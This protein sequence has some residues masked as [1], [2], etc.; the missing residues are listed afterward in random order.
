MRWPATLCAMCIATAAAVGFAQEKAV[1]PPVTPSQDP[2]PEGKVELISALRGQHPRLAF[3]PA[4]VERLRR[5]AQGAGNPFYKQLMEYLPGCIPPTSAKFQTDADDAQRQAF[6]RLPT[7]ALHYVL[8]GEKQSLDR[9]TGYLKFFVDQ[10]NWET[11]HNRDCEMSA[12]NIMTGAALAY[13][14]LYHDLDPAF[15]EKLRAKLFT[16][17]RRMYYGGHLKM[18]GSV[19]FWQ[20]DPQNNHRWINDAGLALCVLAVADETPGSGWLLEKT[21]QELEFIARW[22]PKDGSSHESS[23]Y[24]V[25]GMPYLVLAFDAADRCLGTDLLSHDYFKNNVAFRRHTLT[26]GFKDALHYA[27]SGGTGWINSYSFK[28]ASRNKLADEQAFLMDF[29]AASPK[30]FTYGWP[31]LIWFDDSLSGG[32]LKKLDRQRFFPDI[33]IASMRDGW[34]DQNVAA[35]FKCSPYGGAAL[36]EFRN[37]NNFQYVNVAHDD[38]DANIFQLY[39]RGETVAEDDR[40][41]SGAKLTAAHNTILVDGKGQK[42]EG[43]HWMQPLRGADQDMTRMAWITA[44]KQSGPVTAVEGEASGS[45][46]SLERYRRTAIWVEGAY[47]LLLDDIVAPVQS[48]ITWLMQSRDVKIVDEVAGEFQLGQNAT[49]RLIT[50]C[51]GNIKIAAGIKQSPAMDHSKS[52]GFRQLQLSAR[53]SRLRMVSLFDPW[54]RGAKLTLTAGDTVELVVAHAQGSDSWSWSPPMGEKTPSRL[55]AQRQGKIIFDLR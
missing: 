26:P 44:W 25:F 3:G 1:R 45:Y 29:Y 38:P 35:M 33:G 11:G 30:S 14:W 50:R 51:V 27:D 41:P 37:R 42:G 36:N 31:S 2:P 48:D 8:T 43:Q 5:L 46:A 22:L 19:H 52:L 32:L 34:S 53:T 10:E 54:N 39:L 6:W 7:V 17:A 28:L 40:Y 18:E 13:D 23:S 16:H 9:A 15:R 12:A 20:N 21:R 55:T 4:D 24:M 47:I 49:C